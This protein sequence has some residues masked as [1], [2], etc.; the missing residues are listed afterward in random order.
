MPLKQPKVYV[1]QHPSR[2][3][4]RGA[5]LAASGM[6]MEDASQ[7]LEKAEVF[8]IPAD[9]HKKNPPVNSTWKNDLVEMLMRL[10]VLVTKHMF[11]P[12]QQ[13]KEKKASDFLKPLLSPS[14]AERGGT[15]GLI[16]KATQRNLPWAPCINSEPLGLRAA[17]CDP[18][19]EPSGFH[20]GCT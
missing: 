15:K 10:K 19:Q 9:Q 12:S 3:E 14:F 5:T 6:T 17:P 13:R 11:R 1:Y 2:F 20:W 8:F 7:S 18:P 16:T 4:N